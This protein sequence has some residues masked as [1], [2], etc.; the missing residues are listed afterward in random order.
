MTFS[1]AVVVS[2]TFQMLNNCPP[3]EELVTC[4]YVHDAKIENELSVYGGEYRTNGR[5]VAIYAFILYTGS[6]ERRTQMIW[7][8]ILGVSMSLLGHRSA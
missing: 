5:H 1:T 8:L 2:T 4:S 3:F 6:T 7:S